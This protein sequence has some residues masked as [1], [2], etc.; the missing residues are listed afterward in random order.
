VGSG[1]A[2]ITL[3]AART[4][5]GL[6]FSPAAGGSYVLGGSG[7]NSLQFAN[8]GSSASISV[9]SGAS[10]INAPVVLC[11]NVNVA[12]AGGTSLAISGP[13]SQSGGSHGLTLSGGG[14]LA[15]SGSDTYTGGTFVSDGL[16]VVNNSRAIPGGSLLVIGPG[17]S[18]VLGAPG[19]SEPL[20]VA[21]APGAGPLQVAVAAAGQAGTE[22]ASLVVSSASVTP[23][24]PGTIASGRARSESAEALT[25][26]H[27]PE[28]GRSRRERGPNSPAAVDRLLAI[29]RV[30]GVVCGPSTPFVPQGVPPYC[31][32]Y[33]FAGPLGSAGE[34]LPAS[35]V[36]HSNAAV[37]DHAGG[38]PAGDAT[39]RVAALQTAAFGEASDEVLLRIAAAR[40][41][42][43]AARAGNQHPATALFGLDLQTLDL[44][45]AAAT[46]RQ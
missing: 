35:S 6:T 29:Q 40:A 10:A 36:P 25:L 31:H 13:I 22:A 20:A 18:V 2:T 38:Q 21:P 24:T 37:V 32:T 39:P 15:L 27:R 34:L 14:S 1:T 46:Q 33:S 17:G 5:S 11:D 30:P 26:G 12:A 7:G 44:L 9:A 19:A 43:A 3:D 28:V 16:L 45:A 4:V 42:N 41:G 8:S 23:L